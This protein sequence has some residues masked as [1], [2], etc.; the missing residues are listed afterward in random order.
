VKFLFLIFPEIFPAKSAKI[1][2]E[3][4]VENF[5][6]KVRPGNYLVGPIRPR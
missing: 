2:Q 4:P 5:P 1:F 3:N 6:G